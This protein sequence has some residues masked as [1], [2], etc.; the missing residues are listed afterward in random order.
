MIF[1]RWLCCPKRPMRGAQ[2]RHGQTMVPPDGEQR[3]DEA[4]IPFRSALVGGYRQSGQ[5]APYVTAP[6]MPDGSTPT[7]LPDR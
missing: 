7:S 3:P 2:I 5:L 6:G 4:V 1:L